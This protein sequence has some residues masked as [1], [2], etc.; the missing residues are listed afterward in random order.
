MDNPAPEDI[1][2]AEANKTGIVKRIFHHP[3]FNAV[4]GIFGIVGTIL[5]VYFYRQSI[6]EPNLTYYI[7]PTR[8][9]I[10][11]K[12][13]LDNFSV[14]FL[15]TQITGDLSSAQVQIWNQGKAPIRREDIL[16]PISIRTSNGERIYQIN[17]K[18]SREVTGF[19]L[20]TP[21]DQMSLRMDWKILEQNDGAQLQ[22]IYGG[23]VNA[24]LIVDGVIVGQPQGLTE[25]Q[26]VAGKVQ[27]V[28]GVK[29]KIWA[30]I[31]ILAMFTISL[32]TFMLV[33]QFVGNMSKKAKTGIGQVLLMLLLM[34]IMVGYIYYFTHMD[35][36]FLTPPKPPF[37][38]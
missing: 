3:N 28:R 36:L 12:G 20:L 35:E 27:P 34:A 37:G 5:A 26:Y 1:P 2:K 4:A 11:Q 13:S 7:S 30:S 10:V 29:E 19:N 23:G 21:T 31:Y 22:I 18:P 9:P 15:G 33:F 16:K 14:T 8:T 38:F 17:V 6:K 24:P 25:Y 32:I